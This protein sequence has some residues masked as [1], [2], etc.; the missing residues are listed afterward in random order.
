MYKNGVGSFVLAEELLDPIAFLDVTQL[1]A[2]TF[3]PMEISCII[4]QLFCE[5][6]GVVG[7]IEPAQVGLLG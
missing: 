7:G 6:F 4:A 2:C 5:L 3:L 1:G